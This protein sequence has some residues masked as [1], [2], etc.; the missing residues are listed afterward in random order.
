MIL[1]GGF[2]LRLERQKIFLFF[3]M[4]KLKKININIF[5]YFFLK[6]Y[7]IIKKFYFFS[8]GSVLISLEASPVH[9]NTLL[10]IYS[11]RPTSYSLKSEYKTHFQLKTANYLVGRC[12][13]HQILLFFKYCNFLVLIV[14]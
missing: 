2:K 14:I 4:S 13:L 9:G 7:I 5:L 6:I 11:Q 8:K 1:R 12:Y 10:L 3:K